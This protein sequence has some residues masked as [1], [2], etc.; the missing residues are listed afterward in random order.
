M[1]QS[2]WQPITPA[3]PVRASREPLTRDRVVD[4]ALQLLV[5]QGYEAVSMRKV[6]QA[7]GTGPASL[8]AHVANKKELDQLMLDRA[9]ADMKLPGADPE[10]WQEQLKAAMDEIL[11]VMRRPANTPPAWSAAN[12]SRWTTGPNHYAPP[13]APRPI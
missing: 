10:H 13:S 4:A 7:L 1:N 8:Y 9:A 11:R 3:K 5:E 6:A 12:S 2:P